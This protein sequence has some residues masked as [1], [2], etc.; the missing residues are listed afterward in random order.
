MASRLESPKECALSESA[1][2]RFRQEF[3]REMPENDDDNESS[4]LSLRSYISRHIQKQ[5]AGEEETSTPVQQAPPSPPAPLVQRSSPFILTGGDQLYGLDTEMNAGIEQYLPTPAVRLRIIKERVRREANVLKG[6]L[7]KYRSLKNPSEVMQGKITRLEQKLATLQEHERQVDEELRRLFSEESTVFRVSAAI[8]DLQQRLQ[9]TLDD[10]LREMA[11]EKL[12]HK[13]DPE[14]QELDAMNLQ[15]QDIAAVMQDQMARRTMNPE[16]ISDIVN[17]YD[18][19]SRQL[20]AMA[21][22]LRNSRGFLDQVNNRIQE[23]C[24]KFYSA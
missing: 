10:L 22:K 3:F 11:I 13:M 12:I 17:Q 21:E 15:L 7:L 18:L 5:M 19:T 23:A 6:H 8:N 2:K 14:R 24:R 4:H 9:D 1:A 16:E 20:E